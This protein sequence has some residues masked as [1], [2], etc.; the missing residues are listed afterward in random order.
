MNRL[1]QEDVFRF[2]KHPMAKLARRKLAQRH[3]VDSI[4]ML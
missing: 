1:F 4:H 3:V 2:S